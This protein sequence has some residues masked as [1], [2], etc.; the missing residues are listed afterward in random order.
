MLRALHIENIA[1]VKSLDVELGR[2]FNVLTGETGAG[3]SIIIDSIGLLLGSRA[4]REL[5]RSGETSA[6]VC[7]VFCD[8]GETA[9]QSLRGMGFECTDSSVML[10]RTI[11]TDGKS[12]ARI[13]G[14]CV[15]LAVLKEV[16]ALLVNIHGQ[17]DNRRLMSR[18]NHLLMLDRFACDAEVLEEYAGL[19]REITDVRTKAQAVERD[20]MEKNRLREMLLYQI[21]D[22]ESAKLKAGEEEEL[23]TEE[24]K[25][26]S[27][28]Y[29]NK[30]TALVD[31][32]L[33]G[34][35]RGHGA[36]Y[37]CDRAQEALSRISDSMPEA[38]ELAARLESI[39]YELD[40]IAQTASGFGDFGEGDP[41]ARL[42]RIEARLE[43]ISKLKRKYGSSIPEILAYA[44]D[45]SSRLEEIDN[46]DALL[47]ELGERLKTLC[48]EADKVAA[49]LTQIRADA[50]R[51]L[52]R[53][54]TE[55]LTFLDMPKV[56]FEVDMKKTD[57]FTPTGRDSLE[58][59]ISA[60]PGEPPM[61]M[62]KIAS[63]G[64][65]AR[66]MLSL[67]GVLNLTDGVGTLIYDEIDTGIS[68]KTSRKVGIRLKETAA[69]VQVI[70]VTHSA[71]I[72]SLGDE[73]FLIR[74]TESGGRVMT[75]LHRLGDEERVDEIARILG[76]IN[77]TEAQKN[78]AREMIAEGKNYG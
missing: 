78:A 25:L 8:I 26:Q 67:C 73:H 41:T 40:D 70:C 33:N 65:L 68:G 59:L 30:C 21:A 6:E 51:E 52:T 1:V 37:L 16:A 5:I 35:E 32:A 2:G 11:S 55:S 24:K 29:I 61:P 4:D 53:R 49:K 66:I 58:F 62:I 17:N 36:L 9:E 18:A 39:R 50:A 77:I 76:G 71:Q 48:A 3:K 69:S 54:V 43:V 34:S 42:D 23:L 74:K 57:D 75:E 7:A 45:A 63:G 31:R 13:D 10:S 44:K 15:T 64:E 38:G 56:R 72:A 28:E 60:N 12:V 20:S 19:Y 46:S 22:I 27:I 14:R 47:A